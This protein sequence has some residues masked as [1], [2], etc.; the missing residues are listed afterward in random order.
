MKKNPKKGGRPKLAKHLRRDCSLSFVRVTRAQRDAIRESAKT[1]GAKSDAAWV[2]S[3]L[4][5]SS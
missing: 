4:G 1:Y 5:L 2:L 3:K